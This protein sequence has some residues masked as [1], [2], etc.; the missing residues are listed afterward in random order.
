ME[1]DPLGGVLPFT[2][3]VADTEPSQASLLILGVTLSVAGDEVTGLSP[4]ERDSWGWRSKAAP[5]G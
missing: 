2:Q 1:T 4:P 3:R 5:T